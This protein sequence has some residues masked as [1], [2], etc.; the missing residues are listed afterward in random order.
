MCV[1][2]CVC[3]CVCVCDFDP[4]Q[5]GAIRLAISKAML[6]FPGNH[7]DKLEAGKQDYS[8]KHTKCYCL[9]FCNQK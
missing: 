3:V 8:A 2:L 4:G 5:A 9:F 7:G 1:C 6:A